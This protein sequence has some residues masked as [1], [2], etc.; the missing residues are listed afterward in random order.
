MFS[1]VQ[2][3]WGETSRWS[4]LLVPDSRAHLLAPIQTVSTNLFKK[5]KILML[6]SRG[7]KAVLRNTARKKPPGAPQ[8]DPIPLLF[9]SLQE[10]NNSW[11]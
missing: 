10:I 4:Q 11:L 2:G 7:Q 6:S 3:K 5:G 9:P 1:G 8:T